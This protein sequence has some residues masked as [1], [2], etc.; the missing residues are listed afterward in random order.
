MNHPKPDVPLKSV[1][2]PILDNR[3]ARSTGLWV[4][5]VF[6]TLL[7]SGC[8]TAVA[9]ADAVGSAAVYTVKTVVNTVDAVTPD[10]VNGDDDD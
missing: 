4:S 7:L 9:V 3:P 10:I 6:M 2:T 5:A 1:T 8:S